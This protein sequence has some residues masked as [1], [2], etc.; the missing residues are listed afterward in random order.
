MLKFHVDLQ[1]VNSQRESEDVKFTTIVSAQDADA[2]KQKA[3][4][5]LKE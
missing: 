2:A 5:L 4:S 1:S 3:Q